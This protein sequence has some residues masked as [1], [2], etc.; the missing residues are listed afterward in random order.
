MTKSSSLTRSDIYTRVT[1]QIIEAIEA[2]ADDYRMPWHESAGGLPKNA[3]TQKPYRGINTLTLW[4][5]SRGKGYASPTWAT[6]RQWNAMGAHIRKGEKGSTIVFFKPAV[7]SDE[8]DSRLPKSARRRFILKVSNVFNA[9]QVEGWQD[10]QAT[11]VPDPTER[12]ERADG[13][14]SSLEADIRHGGDIAAYNKVLDFIRMPERHR[15][16]GTA[17]STPT[18][19][20]YSVLLHEHVHWSGHRSRLDRVLSGRFG[21]HAYAMEELV[22]ELGAAFLCAEL[23]IS[24]V[25]R[26][27]HAAYLSS[28]LCVLQEDKTAL[29]RAAASAAD[30]S[31]YLQVLSGDYGA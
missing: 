18:E 16:V 2:G 5:A 20:Y 19:A 29:F 31:R 8:P 21:D 22:A 30:A 12:L 9:N 25:P 27:D 24:A 3:A 23:G 15:F 1:D 10:E 6:L 26:R 14:V 11:P 17:T 7:D 4:S 28:W 13:F